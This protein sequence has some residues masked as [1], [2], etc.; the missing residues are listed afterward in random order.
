[1]NDLLS[2]NLE[3]LLNIPL[4][5]IDGLLTDPQQ[6]PAHDSNLTGAALLNHFHGPQHTHLAEAATAT[7]DVHHDDDQM[8]NWTN[9]TTA[10]LNCIRHLCKRFATNKCSD[11]PMDVILDVT[12]RVTVHCKLGLDKHLND[13]DLDMTISLV[14]M[15]LRPT[16]EL[17]DHALSLLKHSNQDLGVKVSI[18]SFNVPSEPA[19]EIMKA[20]ISRELE[21]CIVLLQRL[22]QMA[23]RRHDCAQPL[24]LVQ[25]T[26]ERGMSIIRQVQNKLVDTV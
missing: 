23:A 19:M 22:H 18:G 6:A 16:G 4:D 2:F 1:M 26:A 5:S 11:P 25:L 12:H 24:C 20:A 9:T 15:I 3:E 7:T 21:S 10:L 17:L 13:Q 14:M 8:Q